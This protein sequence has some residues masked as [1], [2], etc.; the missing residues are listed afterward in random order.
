MSK[1][2]IGVMTGTS[3]DALDGCIVSF[4]G[5]F[6]LIERISLD[7]EESYKKDY[8]E[9]LMAGY[10]TIDE[11]KKLFDLENMLNSQTVELIKRLLNKSKLA[12]DDI[13]AIGFSG[14]TVFHTNQKSFQIGDPQKISNSVGIKVLSDFRNFDI[15][16]G[17]SLIHIS[18]PTRPY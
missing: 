16:L 15:A 8:E 10:K 14:Q 12:K 4:D 9:C 7:L 1:N 2:F 5:Q 6:Q 3:A 17:L 11:S 18:E 13:A